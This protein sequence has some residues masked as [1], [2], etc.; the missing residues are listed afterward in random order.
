M[1]DQTFR[2]LESHEIKNALI[3]FMGENI[4]ELKQ[5]DSSLLTKSNTLQGLT[6]QPEAILKSIPTPQAPTRPPQP[7]PL[8]QIDITPVQAQQQVVLQ[9]EQTA[10]ADDPNQLLFNFV[11]DLNKTPS[12]VETIQTISKN[13]DYKLSDLVFMM[14]RIEE[15]IDALSQDIS[16]LN[17]KKAQAEA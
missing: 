1:S 3:Q 5:L 8:P 2:A 15:K 13:V 6:L 10:P 17:K 9:P 12:I 16:R 11:N 7:Q 14:K 4:G